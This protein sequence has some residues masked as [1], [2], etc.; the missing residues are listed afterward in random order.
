MTLIFNHGTMGAGKSAVLIAKATSIQANA[1]FLKP[2]KDTRDGENYISSR[3]GM[4]LRVH[5]T[6]APE[7]NIEEIFLSFF[8]GKVNSPH[9]KYIFVDEAQFLTKKNIEELMYIG[10]EYGVRVECFGLLVNFKSEL[11]EGSK[12]LIELCDEMVELPSFDAYGYK[13]VQN[14]RLVDGEI[15]RDGPETHLGKE[16][17]YQAM[18]NKMFFRDFK[19]E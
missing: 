12:R 4:K 14:A 1:L 11:F 2:A 10:F 6:I 7:S 18:S 15:V 16:E 3:N 8:S 13:A 17:S 19:G 5:A 9:M